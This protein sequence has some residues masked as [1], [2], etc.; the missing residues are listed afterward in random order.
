[1]PKQLF[2]FLLL[3]AIPS[4][5]CDVIIEFAKNHSVLRIIED[6]AARFGANLPTK[7]LVGRVVP[8]SPIYACT[9]IE[10]PP[11]NMS[12]PPGHGWISIIKRGSGDEKRHKDDCTFQAKVERAMKANYSAVIVYNNENNAI[13]SMGGDKNDLIPSVFVG[14]KDGERIIAKYSYTMN[15]FVVKLTDDT[16]FDINNYLLPFAIVVGICFIIMLAIMIFKCVQDRRREYR[17]RLPKSSLKKIPTKK[18]VAGD[19]LHYE[20]CCICLD[21]YVVGDKLRI[22]PCDHA[23]HVKCIDPWL[24]KNKRVCPQCRKK[25]FATGEAPPSDSDS[26]TEDER[27]PLLA[28]PRI[29]AAHTAFTPHVENPFQRAARRMANR[30][31]SESGSSTNSSNV[32]SSP[33][34]DDQLTPRILGN[35]LT[36]EVHTEP[37][38]HLVQIEPLEEE[39]VQIEPVEEEMVQIEPVEEE[40]VQIED[41]PKTTEEEMVHFEPITE[42]TPPS[43]Q[44]IQKTDPQSNPSPAQSSSPVFSTGLEP[45]AVMEQDETIQDDSGPQVHIEQPG[46]STGSSPGS[47]V[48][49]AVHSSSEEPTDDFPSGSEMV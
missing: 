18:F 30:A 38:T 8:A 20:T 16:P 15:E 3:V 29:A 31:N 11:T 9:D 7:G 41:E 34:A 6:D 43:I 19:E 14:K 12:L 47:Q 37:N 46:A 39:M 27:A 1:M 13:I 36:A 49:L 26:E 4:I 17:H 10:P 21:D 24:L 35:Q 40:V 25:V 48:G 42:D 45:Y 2:K 44:Y 28:R 23:Y 5:H 22:L 32:S 33:E